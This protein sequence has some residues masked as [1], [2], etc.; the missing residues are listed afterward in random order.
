[1]KKIF[2]DERDK[3]RELFQLI[4]RVSLTTNTWTTKNN[5]IILGIKIHWINDIWGCHEQLLD[6]GVG[7]ITSSYNFGRGGTWCARRV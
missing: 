1:M 6:H 7:C 5:V 4:E 3:I 2:E